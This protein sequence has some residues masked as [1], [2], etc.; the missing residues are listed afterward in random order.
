MFA[1]LRV[2]AVLLGMFSFALPYIIIYLLTGFESR[3]STL[4]QRIWITLWIAGGQVYGLVLCPLVFG[5]DRTAAGRIL[6][7]TI[8]GGSGARVIFLVLLPGAAAIGGYVVV[9]QTM[10]TDRVCVIV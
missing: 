3:E 6:F 7:N 8:Y 2:F 5:S 10:L 4:S 9:A 1:V